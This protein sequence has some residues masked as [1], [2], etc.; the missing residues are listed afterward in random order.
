M[1]NNKGIRILC[2]VVCIA[3]LAAAALVLVEKKKKEAAVPPAVALIENGGVMGEG[4]ASFRFTVVDA[5]GQE[6]SCEIRTDEKT[7]GAALQAL[8]LLYGEE[9]PYGLY[10]KT[11]NGKTYDYDKDGKFWAFYV[12]GEYGV[13]GVDST[14]VEAG[15]EYCFRAE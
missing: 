5:E 10:V 1:K 4:A 14:E 3:L 7:V 6:A 12:N 8:N 9:G 13:N 2:I 11:V 15:A